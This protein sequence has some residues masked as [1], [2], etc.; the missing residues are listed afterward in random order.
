MSRKR[1][2][3]GIEIGPEAVRAVALVGRKPPFRLAG[4]EDLAIG[5]LDEVPAALAEVLGRL[6]AKGPARLVLLG[7]HGNH[8]RLR[9][10]PMRRGELAE[11]LD[12]HLAQVLEEPPAGRLIGRRV[13]REDDGALVID[14]LALPR[15]PV[16]TWCAQLA[17][18]GFPVTGLRTPAA[19]ALADDPR[20]PGERRGG[21]LWVDAGGTRTV[22]TFLKGDE[23]VLVR[24]IP[25]KEPEEDGQLARIERRLADF[26]EIER[27]ILYYRQ[28]HDRGG[29]RTLVLCGD[30]EEV[31]PLHDQIAP[32]LRELEVEIRL[33]DAW[34]PVGAGRDAL[35]P[36]AGPRLA[37]AARTAAWDG[38]S[39]LGIVPPAT[40]ASRRR[41]LRHR[42]LAGAAAAAVALAGGLAWWEA[43][44][45]AHLRERLALERARLAS[46][47]A[48]PTGSDRPVVQVHPPRAADWSGLLSEIGVLARPGIDYEELELVITA[49][50]PV[51]GLVGTAG[52]KDTRATGLLLAGLHEGVLASAYSRGIPRMAAETDPG[53][54]RGERVRYALEGAVDDRPARQAE[55][56]GRERGRR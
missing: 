16:E 54:R 21:L 23:I 5:G 28:H 33:V 56:A 4:A 38:G 20:A 48:P 6:G 8:L 52:G 10:P 39:G 36:G 2:S 11:A 49:D 15:D 25:R 42:A 46:L 53:A 9:F 45:T 19:A 14:V 31:Q 17:A 30:L 26:Q 55:A 35:S 27:S 24:E 7:L 13:R 47:P 12:L 43:S 3:I 50:G 41:T 40:V 29:V 44:A 22:L 1:A 18:S 51:V 34:A 37:L 32:P